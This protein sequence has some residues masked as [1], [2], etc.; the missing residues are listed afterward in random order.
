[1]KAGSRAAIALAAALVA[2]CSEHG[3]QPRAGVVADAAADAAS[4]DG[5]TDDAAVSSRPPP[6]G[7]PL[8]QG[9]PPPRR[10]LDRDAQLTGQGLSS[11][12]HQEPASGDGHRWCVFMKAAAS[13]G[14][15]E[16]WVIDVT[17]AATGDV[18]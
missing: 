2:A 14:A 6:T 7:L 15:T 10:F 18:P 8:P 13:A 16:L 11:C 3:A 9:V 12:S 5:A 1:M 4:Q 17:R